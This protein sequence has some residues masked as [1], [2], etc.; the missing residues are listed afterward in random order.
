MKSNIQKLREKLEGYKED[1]GIFNQTLEALLKDIEATD[2]ETVWELR[3]EF[4]K[5]LEGGK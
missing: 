4:K 3:A 2:A 1:R 5:L